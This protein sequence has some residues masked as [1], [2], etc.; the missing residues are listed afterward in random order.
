MRAQQENRKYYKV[1]CNVCG[2][3]YI[4][5]GKA[6]CTYGYVIKVTRNQFGFEFY[7][8]N[9]HLIKHMIERDREKALIKE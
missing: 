9:C 5:A 1:Y 8:T 4:K 7:S 6:K 3:S 2:F